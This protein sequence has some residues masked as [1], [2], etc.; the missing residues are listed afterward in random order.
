MNVSG[1]NRIS[2][3]TLVRIKPAALERVGV[4]ANRFGFR[5]ISLLFSSDLPP[6]LIERGQNALAVSGIDVAACV[7]VSEASFEAASELFGTAP[8]GDAVIG[9]GG[10]RAIDVAKYVAHLAGVPFF[11][12]PTSLSNDGFASPMA[13]LTMRGRRRSLPATPPAAV[14]IDT[15]LCVAAPVQL[16]WSGVGDL[17]AKLTA[18]ADWKLSFHETG[19]VVDDFAAMLA[20][21]SVYQFMARPTRDREGL[22]LL[23]TALLLNGITMAICGSSR[24]ASGS[25]HLISHALDSIASRPRLHGLQVG[26]ATYIVSQLHADAERTAMIAQLFDRTDFWKGVRDDPFS[27]EDWLQAVQLA[28]SMKTDRFTILSKKNCTSDII[29]IIDDDERLAGC[30]SR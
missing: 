30:F 10:G 23:G 24:P 19:E 20:V 29:N 2:V 11:A 14:V 7:A 26:L 13:S 25:E 16:W 8:I 27:Y 3:P 28:P 15:D 9:L 5:R 21:A 6:N 12:L 18:V 22:R 4:Y 17:S 1:L